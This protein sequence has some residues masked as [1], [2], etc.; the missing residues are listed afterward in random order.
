MSFAV[1]KTIACAPA[2]AFDKMADARNETAWN[3]EVSR[4][5]LRSGEPIEQ[6]S[7][8]L[9][10]NRG[11]EYDATIAAYERPRL[12]VFEVTGKQMDVTARFT[13]APAGEGTSF[14]GEFDMRPKGGTKLAFPLLK[15][16]ITKDLDKQSQ[17]FKEFC[18]SS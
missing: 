4:S 1:E 9:T 10:V 13:F 15:P 6:G 5:E 14:A 11:K 2:D 3:S 17:S 12:L 8:F 16:L 7:R 18:E